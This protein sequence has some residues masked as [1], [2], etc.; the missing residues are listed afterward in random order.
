M[1]SLS[2]NPISFNV[3]RQGLTRNQRGEPTIRNLHQH[4][5]NDLQMAVSAELLEL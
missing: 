3:L 4:I 2:K 1:G 5:A